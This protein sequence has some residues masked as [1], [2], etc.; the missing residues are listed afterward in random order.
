MTNAEKLKN[1]VKEQYTSLA[2][3]TKET[4]CCS[5]TT[6]RNSCCGDNEVDES[7]LTAVYREQEGYYADADLNLGC[8]LPTKFAGIEPGHT[9]V[10]L[11]SG[12][13]NDVFIARRIAGENGRVIGVDMTPEMIERARI[14]ND[15]LRY[16]NVEFR[17]GEIEN[18]PLDDNTADVIISNCVLNLAPDKQKAFEEI[19]RSLKPGGHFCISDIVI[20]GKMS[21]DL[22][23][24]AEIYAGCISGAVD[25]KDYLKMI[26]KA[27]FENV[28]IKQKIETVLDDKLLMRYISGDKLE[29]IKTE[30]KGIFS[31]TVTGE[32][33]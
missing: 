20:N 16:N 1:M 25:E 21:D 4:G 8:G 32:K 18:L 26:Y 3:K 13:G 10:D 30:V 17:L 24:I 29:Q 14:N 6:A 5:Q 28:Q 7:L 33:R 19:Y 2:Q 9:V 23:E 15:K 22:K 12:A 31:I 27:G 11:G